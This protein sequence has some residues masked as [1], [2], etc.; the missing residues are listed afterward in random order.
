MAKAREVA[1]GRA[2]RQAVFDGERGKMRVWDKITVNAGFG[3]QVAEH[4]GM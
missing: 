4:L 2:Q 1:V 3:E